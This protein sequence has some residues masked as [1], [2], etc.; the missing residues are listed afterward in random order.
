MERGIR[1][2]GRRER[3]SNRLRER[4]RE[5]ERESIGLKRFWCGLKMTIE[6]REHLSIFSNAN[7]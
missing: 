3:P 5:R 2:R 1:Q 6:E 7:Q 4:E